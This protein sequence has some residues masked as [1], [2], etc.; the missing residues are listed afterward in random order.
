MSVYCTLFKNEHSGLTSKFRVN[1][2]SCGRHGHFEEYL[3]F[4]ALS[5]YK[6]GRGVTFLLLDENDI[7]DEKS[8]IGFF[9]LR[10]SSL[11]YDCDDHIEG[12]A[13]IEITELAVDEDYEHQGY[14]RHLV[15]LAIDIIDDLRTEYIGI[16]Y[17]VLCSDPMSVSFYERLQFS[18]V[19]D[20]Y[21]IPREGW[22]VDC[23]PMFRRLP[24]L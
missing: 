18:K 5:D 23:I 15:G 16:Q 21:I 6:G 1:P 3:R 10:A 14:G 17:V 24:E 11:T 7:T 9:S 13:A 22:N 4:N 2:K 8:I 20:Y 12:R 19:S